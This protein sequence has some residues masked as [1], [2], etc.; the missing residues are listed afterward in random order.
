MDNSIFYQSH[1]GFFLCF[2]HSVRVCLLCCSGFLP[3]VA[4]EVSLGLEYTVWLVRIV[5]VSG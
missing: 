3:S 2:F 1:L 5:V 4:G